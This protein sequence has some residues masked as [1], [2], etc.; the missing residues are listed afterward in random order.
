MD[1][2]TAYLQEL[3]SEGVRDSGGFFSLSAEKVAERYRGLL[4]QCPELPWLRWLQL[5]YRLRARRYRAQLLNGEFRLQFTG[6]PDLEDLHQALLDYPRPIEG[7]LS[8][9]HEVLWLFL[10]QNPQRILLN[11]ARGRLEITPEG[12]QLKSGSGPVEEDLCIRVEFPPHWLNFVR[13]A[14]TSAS[15][16]RAVCAQGAYLPGVLEWDGKT[17]SEPWQVPSKASLVMAHLVSREASSNIPHLASAFPANLRPSYLQVAEQLQELP[18]GDGLWVTLDGFGGPLRLAGPENDGILMTP[19]WTL[20]G[21]RSY[22]VPGQRMRVR[23]V[24]AYRPGASEWLPVID[25]ICLPPRP[26]VGW[27]PGCWLVAACPV[28][29]KTDYTGLKL[30]EG[31][32]L[33][34]FLQHLRTRYARR[35]GKLV[36]HFPMSTQRFSYLGDQLA[37]G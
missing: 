14:W 15:I 28:D 8:L 20:E 34:G 6:C 37:S 11:S 32:A 19:Q 7:R 22:L 1:S 3:Q 35:I 33:Q 13:R 23:L 16:H 26:L 21:S 4:S 25:G 24:F 36:S 18:D 30:V 9:L 27:P 12:F 29:L 31:E 5:A 2:L 17:A 10:A